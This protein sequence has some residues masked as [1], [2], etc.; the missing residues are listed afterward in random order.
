MIKKAVRALGSTHSILF[1]TLGIIVTSKQLKK[2][3]EKWA[4]D[5][6]ATAIA[7]NE[8]HYLLIRICH[9]DYN[10]A[11]GFELL[12]NDYKFAKIIFKYHE[13]EVIVP[14]E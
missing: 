5:V 2:A 4:E 8:L 10:N 14:H 7:K 11:N 6:G 3:V 12:M 9:G 1:H 13:E